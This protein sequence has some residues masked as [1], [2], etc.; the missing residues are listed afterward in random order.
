MSNFSLG[1]FQNIEREISDTTK[2]M[3]K[4]CFNQSELVYACCFCSYSTANKYN[5]ESHICIHT[6][7]RPYKCPH[8]DKRFTQ[9]H[10]LQN[11]ILVHFGIKPYVCSVCN[12]SF[13][14]TSYLNLHK[15]RYGH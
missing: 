2:E 14:R 11:H 13:R 3:V 8:C 7:D 10:V 12:Q 9:K 6:G 4:K 15:K 5:F 1:I